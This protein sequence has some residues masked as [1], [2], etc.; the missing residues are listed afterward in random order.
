M[1]SQELVEVIETQ[2]RLAAEMTEP[3]QGKLVLSGEQHG[4]GAIEGKQL[5]QAEAQ[6]ISA[7]CQN[8]L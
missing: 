1:T 6:S 4:S 5:L 7:R 8:G 2:I 3:G